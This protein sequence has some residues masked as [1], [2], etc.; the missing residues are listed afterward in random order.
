[1][2]FIISLFIFQ[3]DNACKSP[4]LRVSFGGADKTEMK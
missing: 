2:D 3:A 1:M 4:E